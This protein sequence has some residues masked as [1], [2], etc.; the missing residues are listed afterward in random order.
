MFL[1]PPFSCTKEIV[2]HR[3]WG[4]TSL[5]WQ[6][7]LTVEVDH[8]LLYFFPFTTLAFLPV[9]EEEFLV[10][11]LLRSPIPEP[12]I[13]PSSEGQ[14]IWSSIEKTSRRS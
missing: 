2:P 7:V 3:S 11:D 1:F 10:A 8:H 6:V 14:I 4:K 12:L 13:F 5:P 9:V